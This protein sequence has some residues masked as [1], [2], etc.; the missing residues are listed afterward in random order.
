MKITSVYTGYI[1]AS[2]G[3]ASVLI[4]MNE[5]S[6]SQFG[7]RHRVFC[8]DNKGEHVSIKRRSAEVATEI[9]SNCFYKFKEKV[10]RKLVF[11]SANV[12]ESVRRHECVCMLPIF[13]FFHKFRAFILIKSLL[14]NEGDS[15]SD[16]FIVHDIWSLLEISSSGIDLKKVIFVIHGSDDPMN[17]ILNIFPKLK[18]G[19]FLK[20]ISIDFSKII[21]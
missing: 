19:N 16:F 18:G 5:G 17:F 1:N 4:A 3:V 9:K 11:I 12:L 14:D 20:K 6:W 7:L 15:D 13:Q 2:S 8:I 21:S 10:F